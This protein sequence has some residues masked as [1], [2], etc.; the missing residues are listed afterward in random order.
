MLPPFVGVPTNSALMSPYA[1]TLVRVAQKFCQSDARKEIFRGLLGLRQELANI[2]IVDGYQWLSGSFLENIE[3]L[4]K[5]DPRDVDIV[6]VCYRPASVKGDWSA[7]ANLFNTN[8]R[9][10]DP[11][12]TKTAFRCDARYIDLD[13]DGLT[14]VDQTRFWFGLFSHRRGG[15]WKG[16]LRVPLQVTQD[17]ADAS[18]IVGSP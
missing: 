14:I 16:M 6:T 12:Q 10:F 15:L 13:M 5:R 17:D 18:L 9:L 4:E 3:W 2:G 8:I 1:T 7:W 11:A